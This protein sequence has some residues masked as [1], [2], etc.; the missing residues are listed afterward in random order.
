[1]FGA[2]SISDYAIAIRENERRSGHCSQGD[3]FSLYS[4]IYIYIVRNKERRAGQGREG[5]NE[6][7]QKK[8]TPSPR[9]CVA[10][11]PRA[12]TFGYGCTVHVGVGIGAGDAGVDVIYITFIMSVQY[13]GSLVPY[14][15]KV[16]R[17][18]LD[19]WTTG[20]STK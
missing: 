18:Q 16:Q 8:E 10:R 12:L 14:K 3:I 2:I 19:N 6:G 1:M 15:D 11:S 5:K 17:R 13:I 9:C 7:N 20:Y 4:S